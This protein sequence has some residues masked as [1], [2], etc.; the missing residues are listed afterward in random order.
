MAIIDLKLYSGRS[1][2][3]PDLKAPG[4]GPAG[5]LANPDVA[6]RGEQIIA[7]DGAKTIWGWL[8]GLRTGAG[9]FLLGLLG[10]ATFW[11]TDVRRGPTGA[12]PA[13]SKGV[14]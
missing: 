9:I 4:D 10:G 12:Q 13:S 8:D 11:F 6:T 2:L 3:R 14:T 5:L 7:L 1:R